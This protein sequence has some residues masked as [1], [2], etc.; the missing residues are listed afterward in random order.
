M[1][2]FRALCAELVDELHCYK[3]VHPQHD[4]DL[5]D[6]ARAALEAQ[7]EPQGPPK[8]CWLDD[9]PY[10]CP[11]PCVFD[12]PSEVIDNCLEARHLSEKNK[13]KEAC[14]YY[15]TTAQPEPVV[16]T[17]P[18]CFNFAMDFLGGTEEVEVRN[19]IE[20]LESAARAVLAQPEPQGPSELELEA[21]ELKLWDK[22]RTKGYMGEE[23][24]YDND[25]SAALDEYR[26]AL[27]RWGRPAIGPV[28]KRE[29][30]HYAWELHDAEGEWQAGGS[31]NSL[32]DVQREGNRYLQ[33]YSQ[34]GPHKLI[35]E[36]HCV[37]TI[38]P[39]PKREAEQ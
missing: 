23:F 4:T 8:N 12:D 14:K 26:A 10:L 2:D 28:P 11:S 3:Y 36:R 32:E 13:P 31:A 38:E 29:D 15:R 30:V 33:T 19:Y 1:T 22:H 9:E 37:T 20:R 25:F 39:V 5:I 16:L 6:R 18:D 7:P 21:I 35:I 24:M 17:R 34:A 27:A